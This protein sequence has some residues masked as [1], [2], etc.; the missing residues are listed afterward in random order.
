MSKKAEET[1]FIKVYKDGTVEV[2]ISTV[3]ENML[4]YNDLRI[5]YLPASNIIV[6][7]EDNLYFSYKVIEK[8]KPV[9]FKVKHE[10]GNPEIL[11]GL[12]IFDQENMELN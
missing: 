1:N 10:F 8:E 7:D 9:R 11:P 4:Q 2:K 6:V 5:L 12:R 3:I